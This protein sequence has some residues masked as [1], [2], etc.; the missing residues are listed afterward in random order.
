MPIFFG[1]IGNEFNI[2]IGGL[3]DRL[4]DFGLNFVGSITYLAYGSAQGNTRKGLLYGVNEVY[5]FADFSHLLITFSIVYKLF[6]SNKL[7][8]KELLK[9]YVLFL[10]TIFI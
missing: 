7:S 1:G 3:V 5:Q 9:R 8:K 2:N 6:S 10:F 4:F